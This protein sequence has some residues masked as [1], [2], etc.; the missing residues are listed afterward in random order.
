MKPERMYLDELNSD[1]KAYKV[2]VKVIEKGRAK[3]LPKKGVIY[4]NLLLEDDKG[5]KMR[6]ALFGDQ[7]EGYKEAFVY[8]GVYEIANAPIK[9]CVEQWKSNPDELNYQMTFGRQTII[10]A[11]NTKS[12]PI[13]PEYTEQPIIISTWN[14]LAEIDCDTL[15]AW[16]KKFSVVGFTAL[17]VSTHK[18]FSLTSSMSTTIIHDPQESKARALEDW[19]L[20]HQKALSDRQARVLD[21][22][23]PSQEKVITTIN[24]L[25]QKTVHNT[26][27]EERRWLKVVI[28]EANIDRVNAYLGCSNCGKRTD[29]PVGKAYACT[30]CSKKDC[31]SSPRITFNCEVADGTGTLAITMFT[32]DSEK[33]F[34]MT[35]AD[36]FRVKH[37]DDQIAFKAIQQ[38]LR[39]SDVLIEVGP[40]TTL[41]RNNILQWILKQVVIEPKD[42]QVEDKKTRNE[43][44]EE[45]LEIGT[46]Q[47]HVRKV[48]EQDDADNSNTAKI[49]SITDD[50]K[51]PKV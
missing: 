8:N 19:V 45:V 12:G 22:R 35:A 27:Q 24:A 30:T 13:L 11:V 25:K 36:I 9:P 44:E 48:V 37:S 33:L 50:A 5:N 18:G 3:T 31:V 38:L 49:V 28:P 39:T 51:A 32:E 21:V 7:V 42:A 1:T 10:E 14:Y 34:R 47:V 46:S 26:L 43:D 2:K 6:G 16:T 23:N 41:S 17:R 15:S 20:Q 4:Q 29:V 40:K